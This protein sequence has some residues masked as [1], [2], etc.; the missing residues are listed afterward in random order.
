MRCLTSERRHITRPYYV[1]NEPVELLGR[2]INAAS[3]CLELFW[4][5][6][7]EIDPLFDDNYG[8]ELRKRL[9]EQGIVAIND[10]KGCREGER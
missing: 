7:M 8:A 2:D 3:F 9:K 1:V 4:P 10:Q 6:L 5:R